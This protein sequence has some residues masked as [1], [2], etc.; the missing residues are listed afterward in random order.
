MQDLAAIGLAYVQTRLELQAAEERV[1]A[2][3]QRKAEQEVA[4]NA[5]FVETDSV[6]PQI[7]VADHT[8]YAYN[9]YW[10]FK[11]PEIDTADAISQLRRS[12]MGDYVGEQVQISSLSSWFRTR[13]SDQKELRTLP[14][15]PE[16]LQQVVLPKALGRAFYVHEKELIGLRS[17]SVKKNGV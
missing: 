12:R 5:A 7:R 1:K 14:S 10:L 15:D 16:E 6:H 17:P 11:R 2:L 9:Q 4:L 13:V 3:K 8:I